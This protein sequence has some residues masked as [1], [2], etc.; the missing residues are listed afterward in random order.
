MSQ[1]RRTLTNTTDLT[2]L[3][4]P[5]ITALEAAFTE[6]RKVE[7]WDGHCQ[8]IDG[9]AAVGFVNDVDGRFYVTGQG[10]RWSD[11][12][13]NARRRRNRPLFAV[14]LDLKPLKGF[15]RTS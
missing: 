6:I 8:V 15:G 1:K 13:A 14:A 2:D 9:C 12:F 5:E 11:A 10:C 3:I 7:G 4:K